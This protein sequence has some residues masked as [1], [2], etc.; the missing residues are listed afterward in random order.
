M[1]IYI[2]IVKE[3]GKM[4]IFYTNNYKI[5]KVINVNIPTEKVVLDTYFG[6]AYY[7]YSMKEVEL[8][9]RKKEFDNNFVNC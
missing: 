2:T 7:G 8:T 3:H 6:N 5:F 4:N 9:E 1:H